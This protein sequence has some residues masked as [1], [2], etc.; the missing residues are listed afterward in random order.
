MEPAW[1]CDLL[2]LD[3]KTHGLFFGLVIFLFSGTEGAGA[4]VWPEG[5][6]VG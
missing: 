1:I 6:C 5:G 2:S 3:Y 4:D